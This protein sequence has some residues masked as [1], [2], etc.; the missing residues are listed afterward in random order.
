M[1]YLS[2]QL[3]NTLSKH[4]PIQGRFLTI[5]IKTSKRQKNG[6]RSSLPS[7]FLKIKGIHQTS[8]CLHQKLH[9]KILLLICSF[10][11]TTTGF[12]LHS[13]FGKLLLH[14]HLLYCFLLTPRLKVTRRSYSPIEGKFPTIPINTSKR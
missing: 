14:C 11:S 5:C 3:Q 10:V 8:L 7:N 6:V 13:S 9:S 2:L 4:S 12:L 1:I